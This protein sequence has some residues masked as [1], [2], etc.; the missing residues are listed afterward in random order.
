MSRSRERPYHHGDLRA[1]L[2]SAALTLLRERG[3]DGITLR[4]AAKRAG[5]SHAAPYH[6]FPDKS[7][8]IE[9]LAIAC[10]EAFANALERA[11][12]TAPGPS[13]ERFR[14]V[15]LAYV[16]YGLDHPA[17]FR[18]MNRPELR[19]APP[20]TDGA[21]REETAV[22]AA[23]RKPYELLLTAIAACQADGFIAHGDREPLALTAWVSVHGLTVVL[24]DGLLGPAT[25]KDGDRL[26]YQVTQT[27]GDGLLRR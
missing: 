13:M 27:L 14:A 17:E 12:L 22:A 20:T 1:A 16:Q 7:G 18:L 9:A 6:H 15:G 3:P 19:H 5:V 4:E 26:A 21:A 23:A 2:L 24:I 11:W 8:L 10:F 25:R